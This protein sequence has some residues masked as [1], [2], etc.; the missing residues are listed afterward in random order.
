M[1][2]GCTFGQWYGLVRKLTSAEL[3][4]SVQVFQS[5][6]AC[7]D[8]DLNLGVTEKLHQP[9]GYSEPHSECLLRFL[10]KQKHTNGTDMMTRQYVLGSLQDMTRNI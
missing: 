9:S 1:R 8:V 4:V 7:V 6:W 10:S 2:K 5:K 3:F